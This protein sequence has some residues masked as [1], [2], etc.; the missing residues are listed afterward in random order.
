[1]KKKLKIN[2][3]LYLLDYKKRLK[4]YLESTHFGTELTFCI[5]EIQKTEKE[6]MDQNS[7]ISEINNDPEAL[8]YFVTFHA[9][10]EE[11]LDWLKNRKASLKKP[12]RTGQRN[13]SWQGTN[14]QLKRLFD[15]LKEPGF[16]D[17]K[18]DPKAFT[19]IFSDY[20]D[21]CTPIQWTN[22]NRLLAYLFNQMNSGI[23]PLIS[24]CQ[25]QA[26]IGK[27]KLFKNRSGKFLTA[28]D[29]A[30]ALNSINDSLNGLN[31]KGYEKIDEILQTLRR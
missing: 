22:S 2:P 24:S 15:G 14:K 27:H 17:P 20:L 30:T 18:T 31:P 1:M 12:A 16:I 23:K 7:T 3:D 4:Q 11:Y 21:K 28:G 26:V 25:W 29:L 9:H 5:T 13:L 10:N 19:A 8:D 6:I